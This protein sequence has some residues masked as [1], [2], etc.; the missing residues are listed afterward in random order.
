HPES[1][2]LSE[3]EVKYTCIENIF[4]DP[5]EELSTLTSD[6][7]QV[8][9]QIFENV[10]RKLVEIFAIALKD[11]RIAEN[12]VQVISNLANVNISVCEETGHLAKQLREFLDNYTLLADSTEPDGQVNI[13]SKGI[14]LKSIVVQRGG[15]RGGPFTFSPAGLGA[16][17]ETGIS[18]ELPS[19]VLDRQSETGDTRLRYVAYDR[20]QLFVPDG[21]L[22]E[23]YKEEGVIG[24]QKVISAS[25]G[26]EPIANLSSPVVIHL[27]KI[28]NDVNH[29]CAYWDE[30]ANTW[31]DEG[32]TLVWENETVIICHSDHLTNFAVLM[33]PTTEA[34]PSGHAQALEAITWAGCAIS[35][36]CLVFTILTYGLFK[37][38]HGEK[39]GKTLLNLCSALLVLNIMFLV[40]TLDVSGF[41]RSACVGVAMCVHYSLLASLLWMLVEA[42]DMYQA[43]VTVFNKYE[44]FYLIKRCIVAWGLP[45]VIVAITAVL[46][47]DNYFTQNRSLKILLAPGCLIVLLNTVVFIIVARV[48]LKPKFQSKKEASSSVT[49]AQV[50]G[51]FMVMILLGVTWLF[52]PLA[53]EDARLVF[54][55]IFCICNSLQGCLIFFFRCLLNPEAQLAW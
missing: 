26:S 41:S 18:I 23:D 10:T 35:M 27:M 12:S 54:S 51:A 9:A 13:S 30:E 34:L 31:S 29:T 45:I 14:E 16:E 52:G 33:A 36:A 15:N 32:V 24:R 17:N 4:V 43:L 8:T 44:N 6:P 22:W 7:S 39:S 3:D 38:L 28:R 47:T 21:G 40:G 46:G 19:E 11:T 25:V 50:R 37:C 49:I 5:T 20:S 2:W 48:I 42:V 55:Y 1:E 53:V